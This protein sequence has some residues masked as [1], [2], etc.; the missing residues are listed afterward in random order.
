MSLITKD[1]N[2]RTAIIVAA[3]VISV[4]AMSWGAWYSC[5]RYLKHKVLKLY[6]KKI[7]DNAF[8]LINPY[9]EKEPNLERLTEQDLV[10]SGFPFSWKI[11]LPPLVGS[12]DLPFPFKSISGN[13]EIRFLDLFS[14]AHI[15]SLTT[16]TVEQTGIARPMIHIGNPS[17]AVV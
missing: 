12:G 1:K 6:N 3:I 2:I 15:T 17:A 16:R 13:T 10:L 5:G 8:S 11:S 7:A 4:I 9:G 14:N